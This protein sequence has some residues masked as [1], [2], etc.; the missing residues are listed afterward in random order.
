MGAGGR[1]TGCTLRNHDDRCMK[2]PRPI[3][4]PLFRSAEKIMASRDPD[5]IIGGKENPYL[6]RWWI[7]PRN[8][9][10]NIYLHRFLRS[11]DDRALHDHPWCNVSILL[12]GTYHEYTPDDVWIRR[13]GEILFRRPTARHRVELIREYKYSVH[14]RSHSRELP[15]LTLFITGP[16]V[17]EW[18]FWCEGTRFVHHLD[19]VDPND[20]GGVG[21]GCGDEKG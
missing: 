13:Q 19:F 18:G 11:D 10:F 5:F 7:I 12:N 20:P 17:R 2:L 21:P 16:K 4:R 3:L 15:A 8:R 9:F 1:M 6:L 14:D